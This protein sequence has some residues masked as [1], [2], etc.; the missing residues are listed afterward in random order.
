MNQRIAAAL[1]GITMGL[2]TFAGSTLAVSAA[3]PDANEPKLEEKDKVTKV[4]CR[5]LEELDLLDA[6][7]LADLVKRLEC[8]K[9]TPTSTTTTAPS[10]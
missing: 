8:K 2:A 4:I 9:T 6:P 5:V 7:E 10:S 3:A 1:L